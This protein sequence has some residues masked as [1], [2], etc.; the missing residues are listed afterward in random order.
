[1]NC[2]ILLDTYEGALSVLICVG[3]P[4]IAIISSKCVIT[5]S[6]VSELKAGASLYP[7]YMS[8][9]WYIHFSFPN[10]AGL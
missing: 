9:V 1:M 7:E 2:F 3:I 8:V 10:S 4:I 6:A 5:Q